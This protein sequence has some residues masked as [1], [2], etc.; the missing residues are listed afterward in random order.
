MGF[1]PARSEWYSAMVQG[2]LGV[3]A[4]RTGVYCQD[5][6]EDFEGIIMSY[7]MSWRPR[8]SLESTQKLKELIASIVAIAHLEAVTSRILSRL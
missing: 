1:A 4:S 3:V 5:G 8:V 7:H 6:E 2:I